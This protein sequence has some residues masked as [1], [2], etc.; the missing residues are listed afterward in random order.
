MNDVLCLV[1]SA[2][3]VACLVVFVIVLKPSIG[4]TVKGSQE[5]CNTGRSPAQPA[6]ETSLRRSQWL[7][8]GAMR[9]PDG[10]HP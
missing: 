2:A 9:S 7:P 6:P 8:G 3:T 4:S 5:Y 10:V 1:T